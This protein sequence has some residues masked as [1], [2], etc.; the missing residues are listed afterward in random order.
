MT[1]FKESGLF[2]SDSRLSYPVTDWEPKKALA[3][4]PTSG[5]R[6]ARGPARATHRYNFSSTEKTRTFDN[7]SDGE[8]HF[9]YVQQVH[10]NIDTLMH[11]PNAEKIN[12]SSEPA[13]A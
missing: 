7:P 5:S 12:R 8:L 3:F 10:P 11:N 6:G 9:K 2:A 4:A 1:T 13:A